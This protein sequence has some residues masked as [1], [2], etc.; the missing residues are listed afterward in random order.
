MPISIDYY[1]QKIGISLTIREARA[2]QLILEE[3]SVP[4]VSHLPVLL[5]DALQRIQS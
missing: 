1:D 3:L 2:L 4:E 5:A